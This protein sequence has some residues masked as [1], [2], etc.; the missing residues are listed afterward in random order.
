MRIPPDGRPEHGRTGQHCCGL[1]DV[2]HWVREADLS[3]LTTR[4]R[5]VLV[6]LGDCLPSTAIADS[7]C[8]TERTVKK[9]IAGIFLKLEISSRAEAAV[10]ATC[11]K[12]ELWTKGGLADTGYLGRDMTPSGE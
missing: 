9:H 11:R 2:P 6:A 7:C 1:L 8:I 4:E 5:E 10:I 12:H 3:L